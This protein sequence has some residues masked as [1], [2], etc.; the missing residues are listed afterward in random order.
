MHG[1]R[2]YTAPAVHNATALPLRPPAR[3]TP[4]SKQQ[5]VLLP[6]FWDPTH[7]PPCQS[8]RRCCV[9]PIWD[10]RVALREGGGARYAHARYAQ[11]RMRTYVPARARARESARAHTRPHSLLLRTPRHP[12]PSHAPPPRLARRARPS[13]ATHHSHTRSCS[14]FQCMLTVNC[15]ISV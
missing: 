1:I 14:P 11:R 5:R 6:Q 10:F 3:A 15:L 2:T 9:R 12:V 4:L 13:H 8:N 7:P